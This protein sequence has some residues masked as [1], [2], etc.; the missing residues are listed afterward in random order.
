MRIAA[1]SPRPP[2]RRGEGDETFA[3]IA[4]NRRLTN[5][6]P[7]NQEVY[8]GFRYLAELYRP[9]RARWREK[10]VIVFS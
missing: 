3:V 6:E 9:T 5:G 7:Q 2:P 4:E 8:Y 10:P 1:T